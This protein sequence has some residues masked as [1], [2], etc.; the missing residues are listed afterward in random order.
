VA[1]TVEIILRAQNYL[2][3]LQETMLRII[4]T[5]EQQLLDDQTV[6]KDL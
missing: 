4:S 6:V 3:K 2:P 1:C 5:L